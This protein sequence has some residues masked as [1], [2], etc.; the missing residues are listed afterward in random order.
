MFRSRRSQMFFKMIV[1]KKFVNFTGKKNVH[2]ISTTTQD[3]TGLWI[4]F[5]DLPLLTANLTDLQKGKKTTCEKWLLGGVL[6]NSFSKHFSKFAE[7]YLCDSIF[8]TLLKVFPPSGL[9]LFHRKTSSLGLQNKPFVDPLEN[10]CSWIIYKIHRKAP[11]FASL[12]R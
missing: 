7:K 2:L 12:F 10:K 3:W 1:L 11:D 5:L 6:Q 9:Q 8:L 4:P